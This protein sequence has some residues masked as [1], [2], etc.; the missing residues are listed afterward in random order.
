MIEACREVIDNAPLVPVWE[1]KFKEDA[2]VRMVHFGT[3]VE[4]NDLTRYQAEKIVKQD[5]QRDELA[6]TVARRAGVVA[7]ERDVQ[8]VINYRNVMK[9]IDQLVRLNKKV[10]LVLGEKE[11]LQVQA[12]TVEKIVPANEVGVYRKVAVTIRGPRRGEI[13]GRPP[14]SIEVP[15]QVE[16]FFAWFLSL[17]NEEVHPVIK[18]AI[19]HYE[20]V[21]IH[22]FTEG[23]GRVSRAFAWL[24]LALDGYVGRQFFSF[25]E[26]FDRQVEDYYRALAGVEEKGGDLTGFIEF[27]AG[28]LAVEMS[29]VK[30]KVRR[31][32]MDVRFRDRLGRQVALTERQIALMEVLELKGEINMGEA[33]EV[34]PMVSD[35]TIW[36]DLQDLKKKKLIVKKGRTKGARYLLRK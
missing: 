11:L 22:P 15:Y 6:L 4:G 2:L 13:V 9:H 26:Y 20:L 17:V 21:R 35:D 16:D 1:A 29:R 3:H 24:S 27:F 28:A 31:L 12:L 25:E 32:S 33:R 23:N 10:K 5:P 19:V 7:Q 34:L 8:E 18:A 30:E 14:Q 36:R